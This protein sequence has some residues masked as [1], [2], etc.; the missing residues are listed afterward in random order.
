MMYQEFQTLTGS[1][2]SY[3]KYTN[4][5]EPE[6]MTSELSKQDFCTNY[7]EQTKRTRKE[8]SKG[9]DSFNQDKMIKA[10]KFETALKALSKMVQVKDGDVFYMSDV[11]SNYEQGLER[12]NKA[13]AE[14]ETKEVWCKRQYHELREMASLEGGDIKSRDYCRTTILP[15]EYYDYWIMPE[16]NYFR[17]TIELYEDGRAYI[18][19]GY[20]N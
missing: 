16:G 12:W 20:Q 3:Q 15:G 9:Q 6:Y 4:K 10:V 14:N 13:I 11:I 5:I 8:D 17:M 2:T 7:T 18:D 1:K 19:C